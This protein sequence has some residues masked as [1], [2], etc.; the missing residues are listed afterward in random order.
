M[1]LNQL[2]LDGNQQILDWNQLILVFFQ[3]LTPELHWIT[4]KFHILKL[5]NSASV[6][7]AMILQQLESELKFGKK[8]KKA[9]NPH[10]KSLTRVDGSVGLE[11][12]IVGK[13]CKH[14]W[15][16]AHLQL[17]LLLLHG[18]Y[19]KCYSRVRSL[20]LLITQWLE[21]IGIN[22]LAN[23]RLH[24]LDKNE[25][26]VLPHLNEAATKQIMQIAVM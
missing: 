1:D 22:L 25:S 20:M 4:P 8:K 7:V 13:E 24:G 26:E 23:F 19:K 6:I 21:I 3:V 9:I 2:I 17:L 14:F 12:P 10:Q 18:Y 15:C 5:C 16:N 11:E